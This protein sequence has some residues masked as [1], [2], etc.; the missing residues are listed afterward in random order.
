MKVFLTRKYDDGTSTVEQCRSR[1]SAE[2]ILE[3]YYADA[4]VPFIVSA[5]IEKSGAK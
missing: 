2:R 5:I 4:V 1:A 3:G